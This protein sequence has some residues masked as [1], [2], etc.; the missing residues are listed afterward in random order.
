[1]EMILLR[2]ALFVSSATSFALAMSGRREGLF[3]FIFGGLL[4][5]AVSPGTDYIWHDLCQWLGAP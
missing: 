1:M 2:S 4:A 5:L 3:V